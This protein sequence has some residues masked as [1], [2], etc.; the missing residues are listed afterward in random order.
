MANYRLKLARVNSLKLRVS[1]RI[2]A[3]LIGTSFITITRGDN[4]EYFIN[5]D[6]DVLS[7]GPITDATNA[8]VAI[9]DKV[10]G[11]YR[12][13]SLAS[14]LVSGLD[15][16]LQAIAA[17]TGTGIL[18]RTSDGTWALR[19]IT[20]TANEISVANG[21]GIAGQPT[22]SLPAALT[23]TGKTITGG[24][25]ASPAITTPTGIVKADVGLG[26]VDNTSDVNKPVS[27][28]QATADA[29][30]ASNAA[31]ANA[32]KANIASPTFTGTPA[33]PTPAV[34][35][36][37]TQ[38][39]TMAAVLAQAASASPLVNGSVAVGTSTRFARADHVHPID[40]S[41]AP[42]ASPTFTGTPAGPTATLGTN[43]TQL[44]TTAFVLANSAGSSFLQAGTGAVSR[45]MQDKARD[46]IDARDFGAVCNGTTDD[47]AAIQLALNTGNQVL[48]PSGTIRV[49]GPLTIS[50]GMQLV[51]KGGL[52]QETVLTSTST[53]GNIIEIASGATAFRVEGLKL[54]RSVTPTAGAGIMCLADT[55]WA[56]INDIYSLNSFVG[57]Q[58][59]GTNFGF[60]SNIFTTG[61]KGDGF[62]IITGASPNNQLQWQL[63]NL[64]SQGNDG[65]GF[66]VFAASASGSCGQWSRF[67][68]FGNTGLGF[69]VVGSS[70]AASIHAI[71]L[72]DSFIGGDGNSEIYLD[73]YGTLHQFNNVCTEAAGVSATGSLGTTPASGI[74][75][76]VVVTANNAHVQFNGGL[77][78]QNSEQGFSI[79]SGPEVT[80]SASRFSS[81]SKWGISGGRLNYSVGRQ[82]IFEQHARRHHLHHQLPHGCRQRQHAICH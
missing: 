14:L 44:A 51:G 5:P 32:L 40:T 59:G 6:Y 30:V 60:C 77:S 73:T 63:F 12:T 79:A 42:L 45:T 47:T 24:S 41:R 57:V 27:T 78:Y 23:F 53:T 75:S 25:F 11:F 4:G 16:D 33:A 65:R 26:N 62:R 3:N 64:S 46:I 2:P 1:T 9:Q 19:T 15:A 36:N 81:N 18:A 35:T 74:G 21:A 8:F 28:A 13:V 76:G 82:R 17:L 56:W 39:A 22:I 68:T 66:F 71:R 38:L 52:S 7:P 43:T 49:D 67:S 37:T 50:S 20:G 34:D 70:P 54:T 31:T 48:L 29:L 55:Y 58:L 80:I 72:S 10:A 69:A 61:S